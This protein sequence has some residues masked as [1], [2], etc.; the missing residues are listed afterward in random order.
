MAGRVRGVSCNRR[1]D[2]AWEV[3]SDGETWRATTVPGT[4]ASASGWKWDD[5]RAFDSED[6]WW[7]TTIPHGGVLGF[8]GLATLA[9][10]TLNGETI[11]TSDNMFVAHEVE[12]PGGG[13][14]VIHCRA[15]EAELA[16]K[17]PRPRWRVPMLEQQQLRWIRTTLLGRTPGWS[18][19]CPA[20]GPWRAVWLEERV[21]RVGDIA[22]TVDPAGSIAIG[23]EIEVDSATLLVSRVDT[24]EP[25]DRGDAPDEE[26]DEITGSFDRWSTPLAFA[27]GRWRGKLDVP[28]AAKWWPHTHGTPVLYAIA[29]E[30]MSRG[31]R[32]VIDLGTTGFRTIEV[33][34]GDGGDFAVRVNGVPV[35]C[36]GACWT[37]LDVISLAATPDQYGAAI[38]Q[39]RAA[40]MNMIRV[41][42]T[43]VYEDEAF[44][45]ALDAQGV[46]LWQD[47]MFANM[48]YPDDAAFT[49]SVTTEVD[50]QVARLAARPAFAIACGNSEGEQQAAMSGAG[51][52]RWA[53][54]LFHEL[55][56]ERLAARC[57]DV[58]YTPS[59]T[60]GGAFPHQPSAGASSYYG[61]GAYLRPLEDARRSE[62]RFA[63]ECLAFANVGVVPPT[64]RVHHPAWKARSPRD[65]GAGW[66]FDDVRDHYVQRLYGIDPVALR[67]SDHERYLQL[68]RIATGEVMAQ[69]FA[70]WR[71]ARS[72]TRGGLVWFLRDLWPGAGWGVV[73]SDGAPK[74]AW[75]ALRR[76]LQPIAIAMSDEGCNGL[77]VHVAN[78]GPMPIAARVELV[79]YRGG[80]VEVGRGALEIAL[81]PHTTAE[82]AAAQLFEGFL[83]LSF[84]YRFGPPTAHVV[85]ARLVA[86]DELLAEAFH[87]PAGPPATRE[88]DVGLVATLVPGG[89]EISAQRF[90]Y[91]VTIDLPGFRPDD[92]GFHLAPGETRVIAMRQV[93][94]PKSGTVTC[95]NA[96]VGVR[97]E[98]VRA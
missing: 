28:R 25:S 62:V 86:G 35:F 96:E 1:I 56:P 45:D 16:K 29:I 60:H 31:E 79:L 37:P 14:L 26:R 57:P 92:N 94:K 12:V 19:P 70:E 8:D 5:R 91:A 38:A 20:V 36:R 61:V 33:E 77:A 98:V 39:A 17:R 58:A 2:L 89:L 30:T 78:D 59:S 83:D 24:S 72:V 52:D 68:G 50:Q 97:V 64:L 82:L 49:A 75:Y 3:S 71:R 66:D 10:V 15:L 51:R 87:F 80:H 21:L 34:R 53:P 41:G 76:A 22:M 11:L 32:A 55:I 85:H 9:V 18:P 47:F 23:A 90:A 7:R 67:V 84:A 63:S 65:L 69:T 54:A 93:D 27:D 73:A 6:W 44:Y 88:A 4:A 40:G 95:A 13:E 48:D 43:M 46:M 81:A 42:G 74:P